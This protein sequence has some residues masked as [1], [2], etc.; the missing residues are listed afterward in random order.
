MVVEIRIAREERRPT[1]LMQKSWNSLV[2][3]TFAGDVV[4]AQGSSGIAEPGFV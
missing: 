2:L 1:L 4:L 3:Y